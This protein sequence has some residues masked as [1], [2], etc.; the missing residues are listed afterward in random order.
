[1]R[2]DRH[3]L[4]TG[5]CSAK[6]RMGSRVFHLTDPDGHEL[7]LAL[8]VCTLILR[9]YTPM[10]LGHGATVVRRWRS[11]WTKVDEGF[12][13]SFKPDQCLCRGGCR[14]ISG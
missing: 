4:P 7:G 9:V 14:C 6:C 12:P 5:D 1:M 8:P 11:R 10:A 3:G 2:G 13:V